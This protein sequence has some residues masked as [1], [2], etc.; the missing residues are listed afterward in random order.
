MVKKTKI[1]KLIP[2]AVIVFSLLFCHSV[3]AGDWPMR[4]Y[5]KHRGGITT[6]QL[7]LPLAE[8]WKYTTVRAPAPAWTDCPNPEG[9]P[10]APRQNFDWSFDVAVVG[11][12]LYFGSSKSGAVTCLNA[13]TGEKVWTFYT[14]GPVRFAPNVA[15]GRVYAGSDDGYAYC[16]DVAD[17]SVIWKENAGSGQNGSSGEMIWGNDHMISV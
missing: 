15:N 17:G 6:E 8:A 2:L 14:G 11:N 4:L 9:Y 5:D 10:R 3:F 7:T 1:T 12:Y 16:L 13:N